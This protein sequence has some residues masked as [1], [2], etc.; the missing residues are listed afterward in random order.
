MDSND[1]TTVTH[2]LKQKDT[3]KRHNGNDEQDNQEKQIVYI[4]ID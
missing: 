3:I 1:A 4:Y 2:L